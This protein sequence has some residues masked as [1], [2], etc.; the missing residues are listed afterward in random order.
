MEGTIM[1]LGVRKEA[2]LKCIY[3]NAH[4][5]GN[6]QEEMGATVW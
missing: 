4:S 6:K 2:W 5:M 3:N 1:G